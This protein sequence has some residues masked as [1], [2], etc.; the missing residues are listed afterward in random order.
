MLSSSFDIFCFHFQRV[1]NWC[2]G[3]LMGKAMHFAWVR[4]YHRMGIWWKKVPIPFPGSLD[5]MDFA[6]FSN[7]VGNW[8]GNLS[9]S[10]VMKYI[11]GW[12]S[13]WRNAPIPWVPISTNFP[14]FPQDFVTSSRAMGYWWRNP[15]I[16]YVMRYTTWLE[17]NGKKPLCYGKSMGTNF[18]GFAHLIVFAEFSYTI[19]NW[20]ENP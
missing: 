15:C 2:Y 18:P 7:A 19:G 10:H 14:G 11:T 8:W 17:S 13:G 4:K 16:S 3:K 1:W 5:S 9:I 12:K 20:L 6:T